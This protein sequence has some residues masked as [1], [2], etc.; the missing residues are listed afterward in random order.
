M[1]KEP[2]RTP[3]GEPARAMCPEGVTAAAFDLRGRYWTSVAVKGGHAD[4]CCWVQALS[5][6]AV[7]I[8]SDPTT[9]T[10]TQYP[11]SIVRL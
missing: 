7:V 1:L 9:K 8:D 11:Y 4:V 2:E 3:L 10:D 6:V 5:L